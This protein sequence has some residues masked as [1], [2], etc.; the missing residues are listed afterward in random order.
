MTQGPQCW[1]AGLSEVA[2]VAFWTALATPCSST[3][4]PRA[5]R[6][7]DAIANNEYTGLVGNV[8]APIGQR[9]FTAAAASA[10]LI[11]GS[12]MRHH[13]NTVYVMAVISSLNCGIDV[14]CLRAVEPDLRYYTRDACIASLN[15]LMAKAQHDA[16]HQ[17]DWRCVP[18]YS[19]LPF[20]SRR[21]DR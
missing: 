13:V 19:V 15:R 5:R 16:T 9:K 1:V 12:A 4:S 8:H 21:S 14:L 10:R 11:G 18:A 2:D 6:I 20:D 7:E 3:A 17:L